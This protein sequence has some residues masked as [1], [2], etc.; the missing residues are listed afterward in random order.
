MVQRSYE[1]LVPGI[2]SVARLSALP[3]VRRVRRL[4]ES[5]RSPHGAA[6]SDVVR[7][8]HTAGLLTYVI[9]HGVSG[10]LRADT[11]TATCG[12]RVRP[13]RR[14]HLDGAGRSCS[15]RNRGADLYE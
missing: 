11:D 5:L 4:Q 15:S 14:R 9:P 13:W 1:F 2:A 12:R 8:V 3:E 6:C 10:G 7:L